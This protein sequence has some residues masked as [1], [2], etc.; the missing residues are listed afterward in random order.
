MEGKKEKLSSQANTELMVETYTDES[1]NPETVS[2]NNLKNP[3]PTVTPHDPAPPE[4]PCDRTTKKPD[5]LVG[6]ATQLSSPGRLAPDRLGPPDREVRL[7]KEQGARS[8]ST[9]GEGRC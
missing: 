4:E 9:H 5:T 1:I 3:N 6:S 2:G 7:N 8:C